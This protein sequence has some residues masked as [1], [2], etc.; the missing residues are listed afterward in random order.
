M[1]FL[2]LPPL[3]SYFVCRNWSHYLCFQIKMKKKRKPKTIIVTISLHLFIISRC[4]TQNMA[5]FLTK[6]SG[7]SRVVTKLW[8]ILSKSTLLY[9]PEYSKSS[10]FINN[11]GSIEFKSCNSGC[12]I[13]SE[14]LRSETITNMSYRNKCKQQEEKNEVEA[15]ENKMT[16][17]NEA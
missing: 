4:E 6:G 10:L 8:S 16:R 9:V 17:I 5:T 12:C 14:L 11:I 1:L 15:A 2:P 13:S 3:F 7:C